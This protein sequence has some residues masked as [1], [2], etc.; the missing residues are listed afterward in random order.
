MKSYMFA[1]DDAYVAVSAADGTF[2]IANLPAG[3]EIEMR[4]WHEAAPSGLEAKS[5]WG[6]G[7][8]SVTIE[9]DGSEDL[10]TIEVPVTA[11]SLP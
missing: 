2:E 8:F 10:G 1:R 7:R 11:F 9:A 5:D 4:V 6:K 3:E